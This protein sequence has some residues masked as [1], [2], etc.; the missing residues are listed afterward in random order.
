MQRTRIVLSLTLAGLLTACSSLQQDKTLNWS[1]DQ[2]YREAK[3]EMDGGNYSTAA[4]YH[5]KLLSR[6]PY[7]KLAQQSMLDLAFSYYRDGEGEKAEKAYDNF[8]RTYPN[9]PYIDYAYY[10]KGVVVYEKD[11]NIFSKLNPINLTQIDP[12]KLQRAFDNFSYLVETYPKSEYSEDA[13]YRMLFLKNLMAQHELEIA[14]YYMR[15]GSYVAAAN[16]AK[17]VVTRYDGAPSVPYAL[18]L[19][20]RAYQ[21]LAQPQLQNDA[22]RVLKMNFASMMNDQE[23]QHYLNGDISKKQSLWDLLFAEP[24]I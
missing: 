1:A 22:L 16:R 6:Y 19:M 13:R 5:T 7:G 17:N 11:V 4:N 18:A 21:E 20:S 12:S 15:R 14:D 23:I 24:K 2:L 3:A 9:H 10:M 8:I